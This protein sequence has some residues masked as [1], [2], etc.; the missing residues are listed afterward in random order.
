VAARP[1]DHEVLVAP[2]DEALPA[3]L[4]LLSDG[5]PL[6]RDLADQR[7]ALGP[8]GVGGRDGGDEEGGG[9]RD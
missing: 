7:G 4:E 2:A 6:R 5:E 8:V 3:Q 9:G 1:E